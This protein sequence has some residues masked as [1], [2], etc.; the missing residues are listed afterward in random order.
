MC[1]RFLVGQYVTVHDDVNISSL[2]E[3]DGGEYT[4][5]ARNA[6]AQVS[7]SN[8]RGRPSADV[9]V[10]TQRA[11]AAVA[12]RLDEYSA[13]LVIEHIS[14]AHSGDYTCIAQNVAGTVTFTVPLTV[15][16]PPRWVIEPSDA[17]VASGH[18]T[19]CCTARPTATLCPT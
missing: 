7:H 14:S 17:S 8:H 13:S 10:G 3:E 15:N 16:V 12:R 6:V 2:R 9:Q 19:W 4:C 11:A 5:T 1:C 18:D